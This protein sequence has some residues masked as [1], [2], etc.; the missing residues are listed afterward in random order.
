MNCR[1][2]SKLKCFIW[3][4]MTKFLIRFSFCVL[5]PLCFFGHGYIWFKSGQ[6]ESNALLVY[7][8]KLAYCVYLLGVLLGAK[9]NGG[10]LKE[11]FFV[12]FMLMTFIFSSFVPFFNTKLINERY[13]IGDLLGFLIVIFYYSCTLAYIRSNKDGFDFICSTVVLGSFFTSLVV[14]F[15]YVASG[16]E[17]VS[18]PPELH[19]GAAFALSRLFWLKI[20]GKSIVIAFVIGLACVLSLQRMTLI[21][22]VLPVLCLFLFDA[23]R[24]IRSLPGLVLLALIVVTPNLD[25]ISE[26]ITELIPE[27]NVMTFSDSSVNQRLVEVDL[28][29]REIKKGSLLNYFLGFGFG[30]VYENKDYLIPNKG[31]YIHHSHIALVS[32][33]FRNGLLGIISVFIIPFLFFVRFR[34]DSNYKIALVGFISTYVALISDQYIYWGAL[35]AISLALCSHSIVRGRRGC[36]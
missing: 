31:N 3:D 34:F 6:S 11:K 9:W 33:F 14:I 13:Y 27:N 5:V 2:L 26:K 28:I 23:S 32:V 8:M 35:F 16:G 7:G 1:A 21:I 30:A 29:A 25:K 15:F 22:V 19:L 18:I 24:F 4:K 17:K 36:D 12:F 10:Y 20:D